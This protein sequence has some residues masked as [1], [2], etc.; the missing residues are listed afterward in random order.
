MPKNADG[1]PQ[2]DRRQPLLSYESIDTVGMNA[3]Q[4]RYLLDG[5]ELPR[6][7]DAFVITIGR[8]HRR[9]RRRVGN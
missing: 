3:E 4:H 5:E 9:P 6:R 8:N 1:P 2:M 7:V